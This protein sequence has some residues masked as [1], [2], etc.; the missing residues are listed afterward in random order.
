MPWLCKEAGIGDGSYVMPRL[1]N[2]VGSK[3]NPSNGGKEECNEHLGT[4]FQV[5]QQMAFRHGVAVTAVFT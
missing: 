3:D 5:R 2:V 4:F 1:A